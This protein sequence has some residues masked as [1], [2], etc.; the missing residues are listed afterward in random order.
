MWIT[1]KARP[2]FFS[3]PKMS[4]SGRILWIS[5]RT[6]MALVR[7][8]KGRCWVMFLTGDMERRL[9][10]HGTRLVIQ[11]GQGK[12]NWKNSFRKM[13]SEPLSHCLPSKKTKNWPM[14]PA[15]YGWVIQIGWDQGPLSYQF[16]MAPRSRCLAGPSWGEQGG[17][18]GAC[19]MKLGGIRPFDIG[20]NAIIHGIWMGMGYMYIY[21]YYIYIYIFGMYKPTI[22]SLGLPEN[23]GIP[24]TG[25]F[26]VVKWF[27]K[28]S[29]GMGHPIFRQPCGNVRDSPIFQSGGY[30]GAK[31][32][33]K[34]VFPSMRSQGDTKS[35]P[36]TWYFQMQEWE[37]E[38]LNQMRITPSTRT[39]PQHMR[40]W[41]VLY[42]F[43]WGPGH[44]DQRRIWSG[45]DR[46]SQIPPELCRWVRERCGCAAC[47]WMIFWIQTTG[48]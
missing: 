46:V 13:I 19:T 17:K 2:S 41:P 24:P 12:K 28:S 7:W 25:I 40:A 29:E 21:I 5:S 9:E 8:R 14:N 1:A 47:N 33:W 39:E 32:L 3:H 35:F 4:L 44:C 11:S 43:W 31:E 38:I 22:Y 18:M 45:Q 42:I 20:F 10:R 34:F 37:V 16:P 26:S 15:F 6:S 48:P 23:E 30:E 36:S 27:S